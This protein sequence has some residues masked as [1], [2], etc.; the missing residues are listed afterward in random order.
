MRPYDVFAMGS[1][2]NQIPIMR[3]TVFGQDLMVVH[4]PQ[5]D[6]IVV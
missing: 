4:R 6:D 5:I 3:N 2:I 1:A